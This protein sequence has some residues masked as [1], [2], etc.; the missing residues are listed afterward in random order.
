MV[1]I[2]Q[3]KKITPRA[4]LKVASGEAS[5]LGAPLTTLHS[6]AATSPDFFVHPLFPHSS[7]CISFKIYHNIYDDQNKLNCP[8]GKN[9]VAEYFN[10]SEYFMLPKSQLGLMTFNIFAYMFVKSTDILFLHRNRHKIHRL[11]FQ[12]INNTAK[13]NI[14]MKA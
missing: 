3:G 4:S 1:Q 11:I 13:Q 6:P 10:K 7:S 14:N 12:T 9:Q 8:Y 2:A 5:R